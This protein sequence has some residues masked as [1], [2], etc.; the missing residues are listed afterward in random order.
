MQ[1]RGYGW[2]QSS[3]PMDSAKSSNNTNNTY[4]SSAVLYPEYWHTHNTLHEMLH[5]LGAVQ[6]AAPF[7]TNGNH[8]ID[9]NDTMC[10]EDNTGPG[11]YADS[12][13][14]D[15]QY[16]PNGW[17]YSSQEGFPID[18]NYNTYFRTSTGSSYLDNSWNAGGR[19]N[20]FLAYSPSWP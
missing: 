18:C 17:Q 1:A 6:P 16:N 15:G 7:A 12:T 14:G 20:G 10:Y 3:Q 9:G 11:R 19:E 4:T 2:F 13:C 8:C 5:T